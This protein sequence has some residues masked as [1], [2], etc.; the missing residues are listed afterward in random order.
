MLRGRPGHADQRAQLRRR[1][2]R[3]SAMALEE[4]THAQQG[5]RRDARAVAQARNELAVVDGAAP[6]GGL[7]DAVDAAE[8][9]DA[10]EQAAALLHD[11][12]HVYPVSCAHST[13][14]MVGTQ[15]QGNVDRKWDIA[16]Y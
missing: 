1:H 6:E 13:V 15:P 3:D 5:L 16:H 9:R 10:V 11:R 7:G 2:W 14:G 4:R 8:R 12:F